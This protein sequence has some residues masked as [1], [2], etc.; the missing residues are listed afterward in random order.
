MRLGTGAVLDR[1]EVT[2]IL[3]EGGMA[4]VYTVRH[5][6]LGSEHVLKVLT[7]Q[8]ASL[9]QRLVDEG[10]VQAT[11][12]HPNIVEVTDVIEVHG[13]P[14]LVM[15]FV[16]GPSLD[17]LLG[18]ER[19]PF[20]LV[21]ALAARILAGMAAA[22]A[23]GFIHRDL[24]PANILVATLRGQL[25]P[26]IA[27]FGL[28]KR[29]DAGEARTRTG[30]TMGTPQYMS[31]EQINGVAIDQRS[32]IYALGVILYEMC[33]GTPPFRG[34]TLGQMLIAH[35]QQIMPSI[36]RKLLGP[37]VPIEIE[38]IIRKAIAKDPKERY[39]TVAELNADLE[40]LASGQRTLA[41]DWYK[42][43]QPREVTAIQTLHGT[44]LTLQV[45]Q[46]S[47][48][49]RLMWL[50]L[51]MVPGLLLCVAG[52]YFLLRSQKPAVVERP[53]ARPKPPAPPP[54]KRE[55]IDMLA[56]RS[57]ALSVLQDGLKEPDAQPRLLAVQ[58]LAASRDTRHR[59][60]FEQ[61][62]GDDD[63]AV[64]AQA[65]AALGQIGAAGA[66]DP[67]LKLSTAA[68]DSRVML[69][70]AEALARLGEPSG[71]KILE[72][73]AKA[74]ADPQAQ[75]LAA[76]TL[77]DLDP[78]H[79]PNKLVNKRLSKPKEPAEPLLI[80]SRR[81]ARGDQESVEELTKELS[82]EGTSPARQLQ[83]AAILAKQNVEAGKALLSK[84]SAQPGPQQV[85]AAQ[86]LCSVDDPTG[87]SL[88]RAAFADASR[89]PYERMLSAQ[90]LGSCGSRKDAQ[91]LAK[92]LR[93]GEKSPLLRQAEGG[94]ILRLA[95][96][97]PAVLAELSLSWAQAALTDDNWSVRESAV[98]MLGDADP[99]RAVPL[100][101]QAMKDA[102]Q[103]V[104]RSAA[105][106]LGRTRDRSAIAVL[107]GAIADDSRD[108]RL[109]VLRS[110]G[111]VSSHLKQKGE[112]PIDAATQKQLQEALTARADGTDAAESVVAAATLLRMGD[113][114]R[115]DKLKQG[116]SADD[117]EVKELA[118]E[119]AT[120]DPELNKTGLAALLADKVFAV[121]FRAACALADQG[122]KDSVPVLR[123]ALKAGGVN[124]FKAYGLLK[125]LG[126]EAAAPKDL[127]KLLAVE[128][129]E[130]RASVVATA[131]SLPVKDAV[132][133]LQRAAK[134]P[135]GAVRQG[136]L[137]VVAGWAPADGS[138]SGLPLVRTL[139]EDTDVVVRSRARS[140]L[141]KL[142]PPPPPEP[143]E[144]SEG[145]EATGESAP[146]GP[147]ASS[148]AADLSPSAVVDLGPAADL[149]PPELT[150]DLAVRAD[151]Q[152]PRDLAA[153]AT[154]DLAVAEKPAAP[155]VPA[156]AVT[157]KPAESK[158]AASPAEPVEVLDPREQQARVKKTLESTEKLLSRG[159]YDKAIQALLGVLAISPSKGVYMTL[160][161][162]Y[163][164]WAE[165]ESD[166]KAK[167]L[168]KKAIEAYKKAGTAAAKA[169]IAELQQQM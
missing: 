39:A 64:Q 60:L 78:R 88:L 56:L 160:G 69:A 120:A 146:G 162:A 35:L 7:A 65:A 148:A 115:K 8:G 46:Q 134:D 33:T 53:Q 12:K 86:L 47:R 114:S 167:G 136:V 20:D 43:Y 94:A 54:R 3:G 147:G 77:E 141:A 158:P 110:I 59:P 19:L 9:A 32:D 151:L 5:R 84:L 50:G 34:D 97:D 118:I 79:T 44:M 123:E 102:R 16:R 109:S 85:L 74:G 161:Q 66:I 138:A 143:V 30:T 91:S 18:H 117:P 75:L 107:G 169:Q 159:E 29:L 68:K 55:E 145:P 15:E 125:K 113:D 166:K 122:N 42:Q 49:K 82:A 71:K 51:T 98:A 45:P 41:V 27:D 135:A 67:L 111:K 144:P 99:T 2:G 168:K 22:H 28:V 23:A 139:A 132:P 21:D 163:Q 155:A 37:D 25:V 101:G 164:L 83:L 119:E 63:P 31:P 81:A 106:A 76:L 48:S 14:G 100:L 73:Q 92:A 93:T 112:P 127:E 62:L 61:R 150:Q 4:V 10:R 105:T 13:A 124:G 137:G 57:Y 103:E 89:P 72:K 154:P 133:V 90:G 152:A 140:L 131:A 40:R 11:L 38:P 126:E 52:G 157:A 96:G 142:L 17:H 70:A 165:Q 130:V 129:A 6:T 36:D 80:H 149:K 121:R 128:D 24:K 153:P 95:S 116:L 87:L 26:K 1:Y 104:R 58:G 108:V 156:A